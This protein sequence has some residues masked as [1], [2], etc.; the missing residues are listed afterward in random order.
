MSDLSQSTLSFSLHTI[1]KVA[2]LK[3]K[4]QKALPAKDESLQVFH[5]LDV[6]LEPQ[7]REAWVT[8]EKMAMKFRGDHL[9]V[10]G[11]SVDSG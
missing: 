1:T 3:K 9:K 2:H 5:E 10:Y 4:Y 7:T 8:Q 11:I 6:G